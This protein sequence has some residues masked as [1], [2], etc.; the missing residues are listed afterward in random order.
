[1]RRVLDSVRHLLYIVF[2]FPVAI[3]NATVQDITQPLSM[4]VENGYFCISE[5]KSRLTDS[6]QL[7]QTTALFIIISSFY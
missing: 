1:M 5:K 6:V 2:P 7:K 4:S 3:S